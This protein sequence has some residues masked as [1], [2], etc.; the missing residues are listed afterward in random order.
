MYSGSADGR[1][2]NTKGF[3]SSN[4]SNRQCAIWKRLFVLMMMAMCLTFAGARSTPTAQASAPCDMVCGEPFIDPNDGQC[5]VEC[6]PANDKC[7]QSCI[8]KPCKGNF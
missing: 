7:A 3:G 6:C 1:E 2:S 5:Y 4:P 8:V